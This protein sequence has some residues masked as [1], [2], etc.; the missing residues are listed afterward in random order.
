MAGNA[1]NPLLRHV[2]RLIGLPEDGP[3]TDGQLLEWFVARR[4]EAA[5]PAAIPHDVEDAFQAAFLVLCRK[6]GSIGSR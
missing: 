3:E 1:S 2:R 6:A 4:D 5:D